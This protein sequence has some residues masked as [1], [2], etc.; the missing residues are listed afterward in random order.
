MVK[1]ASSIAIPANPSARVQSPAWPC[2]E[3]N[4]LA[5]IHSIDQNDA[6]DEPNEADPED[7]AER[8]A[9]RTLA[10]PLLGPAAVVAG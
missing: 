6:R 2:G 3:T 10:P 7:P 8:R 9:P 1:T 4:P 5:L